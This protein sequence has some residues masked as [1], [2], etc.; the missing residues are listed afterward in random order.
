MEYKRIWRQVPAPVRKS[1]VL[2]I[3]FTLIAIGSILIILPGPFTLPFMIGG[4][5]ILAIEFTWARSL[6][7]KAQESARKVDPRKLKKR[8][9]KE[10]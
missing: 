9:P 6:L 5:F 4:L 7:T 3:G 10:L 8:K 1:I 2:V